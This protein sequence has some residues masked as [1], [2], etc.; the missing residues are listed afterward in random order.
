[1]LLFGKIQ[2]FKFFN[3]FALIKTPAKLKL[4]KFAKKKLE[5]SLN[6]GIDEFPRLE[7]V[8]NNKGKVKSK[9]K[10][11]LENDHIPVIEG[12][13]EIELITCCQKCLQNMDIKVKSDF[14]IAFI[15][16]ENDERE[17]DSKYESVLLKDDEI[18]TI[19]FLTDEI[20]LNI[21]IAPTHAKKCIN[22]Y[23]DDLTINNPFKVLAKLKQGSK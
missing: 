6:T 12:N 1:M 11:Y 2:K 7:G 22:N 15:S 8:V 10:L 13:I 16:S 9:F 18:S 23:K 14:L 17:L 5:F 4:F 3:Y 20:L 21:P 19:D